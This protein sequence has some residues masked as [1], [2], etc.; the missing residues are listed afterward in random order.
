MESATINK[1]IDLKERW[2]QL[3]SENSK[4]RPFDAAK[5]LQVSEAELLATECGESVTRLEAD[6]GEFLT[7]LKSLGRVMALTRNGQVVHERKGEYSRVEIMREHG[8]MGQVLDEG[9]DLR[10]FLNHWKFGFALAGDKRRSFQFFDAAGAAIHKVILLEDSNGEAFADLVNKYRSANQLPEIEVASKSAKPTEKPDAE[11]DIMTFRSRWAAMQ[12]THEFFRLISS[13]GLSRPQALRL[14]GADF[15]YRVET[16]S[17]RQ[18]LQKASED[19]MRIMIFVGNDGVIQI[20]SG[21]VKKVLPHND[22]F[23]VMDADF[24]LHIYEPE[25]QSAWVVKKPT[26]EGV[27]TS[28]ELFNSDGENVA[29]FF[30]KRK[31]GEGENE[32]WRNLL[33]NLTR[34]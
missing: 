19:A 11:V 16:M 32:G 33:V 22:W 9:I 3:K 6:W 15:A 28:L 5:Q 30:S 12:D 29:L 24:N 2:M 34:V 7:D 4:V 17:Y 26:A 13:F 23:N 14:A 27:V 31:P 10:L 1:A 25:I 20:H 8:N 18:V 21:E